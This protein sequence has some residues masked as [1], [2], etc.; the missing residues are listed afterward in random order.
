MDPQMLLPILFGRGDKL[1]EATCGMK[2]RER[3]R[4]QKEVLL[5]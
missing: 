1:K 4:E 5:N 3:E 2:K